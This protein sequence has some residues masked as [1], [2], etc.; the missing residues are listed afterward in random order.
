MSD[1]A[2]AQFVGDSMEEML[3]SLAEG[4]REAQQALSAVPAVDAYGRPQPT[5]HLPY[6]DFD[7]QVKVVMQ[8]SPGGRPIARLMPFTAK[9][10]PSSSGSQST[11]VSGNIKGRLVA[12]PPQQGLPLPILRLTLAQREAVDPPQQTLLLEAANTAGERLTQQAVELNIDPAASQRLNPGMAWPA[13]LTATRLQQAV[14]YTDEQGLAQAVLDLGKELPRGAL[15]M[16]VA[17][18]GPVRAQGVVTV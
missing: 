14:V 1:T 15:L 8:S 10:A 4:V 3:V 9:V 12:V 17:S 7:L 5:Y 16:V 13:S 6:L 18:I 2:T 11:E